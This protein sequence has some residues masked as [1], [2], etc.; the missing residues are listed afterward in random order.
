M[1]SSVSSGLF[2]LQS[3]SLSGMAAPPSTVLRRMDSRAFR[4]ASR[5]RLA[6]MALSRMVRAT[7]GCSSRYTASWSDTMLSTSVR[8]WALPSLALVWPSNWASV[9]FTDITAVMPSRTSSPETL[10]PSL[11]MPYF[12]P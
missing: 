4:A 6:V 7:T 11:I 10:S 1:Y 2:S 5:A 3:R 12:R 8:M 9:S